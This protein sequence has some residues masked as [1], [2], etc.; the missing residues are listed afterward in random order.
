M[1]K[2]RTGQPS[3]LIDEHEVSRLLDIE[4]ATI[5]RWRWARRHLP[6]IKVGDTAVRYRRA[7][8]EALIAA[9]LREPESEPRCGRKAAGEQ[10]TN[11]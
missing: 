11:P 6:F 5:R 3:E 4:L 7:D 8:V 10:R 2:K 9:G 1:T